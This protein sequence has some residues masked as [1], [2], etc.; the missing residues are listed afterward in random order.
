MKLSI[1]QGEV[2]IQTRARKDEEPTPGARQWKDVPILYEGV[3]VNGKM[4]EGGHWI[5][6]TPGDGQWYKINATTFV[7]TE[8]LVITRRVQKI[9]SEEERRARRKAR[10]LKREERREKQGPRDFEREALK[11]QEERLKKRLKLRQQ[12]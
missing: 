9:L 1:I 4:A 7:V 6:F 5:Y 8:L 10:R 12:P 3:E 11:A 2:E